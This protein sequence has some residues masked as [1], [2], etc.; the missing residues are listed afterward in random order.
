MRFFSIF[1]FTVFWI[2]SRICT[3]LQYT[4]IVTATYS[5]GCDFMTGLGNPNMTLK[6]EDSSFS[7]SRNITEPQV[8][9]SS[10]SRLSHLSWQPC[11]HRLYTKFGVNSFTHYRNNQ[12]NPT[13][14]ESSRALATHSF[15]GV[16]LSWAIANPSCTSYLKLIASAVAEIIKVDPEY[17]GAPKPGPRPLCI[18][19]W[20]VHTKNEADNLIPY[21]NITKFPPRNWDQSECDPLIFGTNWLHHWICSCHIS[22][23]LDN[24]FGFLTTGNVQFMFKTIFSPICV[25]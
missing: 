11:K 18:T 20:V 7:R 12:G 25:I 23:S 14:L 21:G 4:L 13:F 10:L 1:K 6:Y 19:P 22:Y 17:L 15:F 3:N 5:S 9:W 2:V 8:L 16:F 24:F